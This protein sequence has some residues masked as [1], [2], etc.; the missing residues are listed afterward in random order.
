MGSG[1]GVA[2]LITE[3]GDNVGFE[4]LALQLVEALR[5]PPSQHVLTNALR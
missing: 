4:E 1:F 2:P 5:T 3:H